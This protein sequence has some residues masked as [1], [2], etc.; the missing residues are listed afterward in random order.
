ML[1]KSQKIT[2]QK[3]Y[4]GKIG[5]LIGFFYH[6]HCKVSA[7]GRPKCIKNQNIRL[8]KYTHVVVM[9]GFFMRCCKTISPE[10]NLL[11]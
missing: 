1:T 11:S 7:L 6:K 4:I 5:H 2:L 10:Y 3:T 9:Y 8:L